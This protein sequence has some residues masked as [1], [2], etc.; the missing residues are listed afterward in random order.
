MG[1]KK[2]CHRWGFHGALLLLWIAVGAVLRF[3][4]LA[5]KPPWN[6]ELATMVF[7]LGNSFQVV[8]LDQAIALETLLAPLRPNGAATVATVAQ[9]LFT[10]STHPPVYFALMHLWLDWLP[11]DG[12]LVSVGAARSL[13]ALFGVMAIP[14]CFGLG[15]RLFRSRMVGHWSAALMAVSPYGI[16]QAQEA[17]HYTLAILCVLASLGC[18]AIALRPDRAGKGLRP[19]PWSVVLLWIAVHALGIAVHY[20]FALAIA[21]EAL[22]IAAQLLVSW[23]RGRGVPRQ[24]L[25]ALGLV[26]A[27]SLVAGLV[28]LPLV[29]QIPDHQLTQWIFDAN[30]LT[31]SLAILGRTVGWVVTMVVMLPVEGVPTGVAVASGAI[32]LGF[33]GWALP[34]WI[35]GGRH[36]LG[37]PRTEPLIALLGGFI[38]AVLGLFAVITYGL[39]AD[40]SLAARYHFVYF[41]ALMLLMG[42][43]LAANWRGEGRSRPIGRRMAALTLVLGLLG[44]LTVVTNYG[45]QKP[46]RPDA[47]VPLIQ[48]VSASRPALIAGAH[49]NYEQTRELMGLALEFRRFRRRQAAA[50]APL[51]PEPQFLLAHHDR[52][53]QP[54]TVTVLQQVVD[55][56]PKPFDLW[57]VNFFPTPEPEIQGCQRSR[58]ALPKLNGYKHRLYH[59]S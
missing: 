23:H 38:V 45:Y 26:G 18:A 31:E 9:R 30:P 22:A 1:L 7:S 28:W 20:F 42:A 12:E 14:A 21:A 10:E 24:T 27:G 55:D 51:P 36:W 37:V 48:S 43:I 59:C 40:M 2:I 6:D 50:G 58:E 53:D 44:C 46:D 49:Q 17:R 33:L 4:N 13:S 3:T 57:V 11:P 34:Q 41:P 19:L 16:Y 56:F 25:I 29:N 47:L 52:P 8:P 54:R 32:A 35:A 39:G 15:W 5:A